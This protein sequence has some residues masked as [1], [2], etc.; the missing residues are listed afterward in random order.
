M[1]GGRPTGYSEEIAE[2]ICDKLSEGITH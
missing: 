1:A 2:K